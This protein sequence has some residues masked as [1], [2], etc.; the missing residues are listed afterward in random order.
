M[1]CGLKKE[2]W[3][4]DTKQI[5]RQKG[6]I[7]LLWDVFGGHINAQGYK[8]L[9]SHIGAIYG[10]SITIERAKDIC[11]RLKQKGFAS[12]NVVFG[13]GSYTYQ[14]NTRDTFGFAMKATY[15]EING[16]PREIFKSPITDDGTKI[17]KKGLLSVSYDDNMNMVC[18]DQCSKEQE[19]NGLLE[20]VFQNS[21][22]IKSISLDEIRE[23][24]WSL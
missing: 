17:S 2:D 14:Y 7:E 13:I 5:K 22:L 23:K 16:E 15:G 9:N 11:E 21:A 19:G 6:V 24:L 18:L 1:E 12:T 8:V 10:D 3:T 20:L 4:R